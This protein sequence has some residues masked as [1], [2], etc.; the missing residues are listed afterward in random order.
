MSGD[1][2]QINEMTIIARVKSK[3]QSSGATNDERIIFSFDRSSNFRFGIGAD[4]INGS[5]GKLAFTFT[6][7]DGTNDTYAVS[8]TINL[9]DDLWHDVA[10][11]FK[12]NQAGGLKYYIDGD[13][14]YTHPNSFNPIS[15]HSDNETPRYGYVGNGS[16]APT[17]KG[18]TN[19][20][21]LF[22]G[23]IQAIK[24]YSKS[25]PI[26]QLT[27]IDTSPPSVTLTDT[28][29]DNIVS[30]SDTVL[31]T[32]T[33]SEAMTST[34]TV[35]IS[36]QITNASMSVSTTSSIWS[37]PWVVPKTFNGQAFATVSGNDVSGNPYA[38]TTSITSVSYTHLRAHET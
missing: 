6:N 7:S 36:G 18:A 15:N 12:A 27:G 2:D 25:L 13:L 19:P 37:Y 22:Y 29:S 33:F 8:Q 34:P 1:A 14:V 26:N 32:A 4:V 20:D 38:G 10:V 28:D 21:N 9:R 3:S 35:S 5:S 16:D 30:D 11:T 23:H 24:Y 17:F 31:I